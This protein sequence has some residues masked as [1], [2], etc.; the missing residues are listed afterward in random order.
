MLIGLRHPGMVAA[1]L[2]MVLVIP[3]CGPSIKGGIDAT[4]LDPDIHP[5]RRRV[6]VTEQAVVPTPEPEEVEQV[7]AEPAMQEGAPEEVAVMVEEVDA[8]VDA[9]EHLYID[10]ASGPIRLGKGKVYHWVAEGGE[11]IMPAEV[12]TPVEP[13]ASASGP[14]PVQVEDEAP[15]TGALFTMDEV[16]MLIR[17]YEMAMSNRDADSLKAIFIDTARFRFSMEVPLQGTLSESY[18]LSEFM[19]THRDGWKSK[20]DYDLVID[21]ITVTVS[22]D[23][24]TAEAGGQATEVMTT[25]DKRVSA[26]YRM[27]FLVEKVGQDLLFTALEADGSM[28]AVPTGDSR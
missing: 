5:P 19:E 10:K 24:T 3:G 12:I 1:I 17:R 7:E 4:D 27:K 6:L 23:G 11:V 21:D 15:D 26:D 13:I 9:R 25:R 28:Q 14:E 2:A 22:D 18:S 20:M 8:S 16:V